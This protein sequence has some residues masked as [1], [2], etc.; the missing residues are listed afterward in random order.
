MLLESTGILHRTWP[1][2]DELIMSDGTPF[3]DLA[4]Q[5]GYLRLA[6]EQA[7][8]SAIDE[9]VPQVGVIPDDVPLVHVW[10]DDTGYKITTTVEELT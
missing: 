4:R 9:L 5:R 7:S 3:D 8:L 1:S 2:G 6:L 10:R